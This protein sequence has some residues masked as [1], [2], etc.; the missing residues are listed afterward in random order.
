MDVLMSADMQMIV[1]VVVA[2]V[3][4]V[5]LRLVVGRHVGIWV[6]LSAG[7]IVR[8]CAA[9]LQHSHKL[10]MVIHLGQLSRLESPGVP[11]SLQFWACNQKEM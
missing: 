1:A 4:H 6:E 3:V 10:W 2:M 11:R 7:M 9:V 5:T 8:Y